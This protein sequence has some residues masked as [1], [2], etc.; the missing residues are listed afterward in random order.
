M[1][2]GIYRSDV[3]V[4]VVLR[5]LSGDAYSHLGFHKRRDDLVGGAVKPHEFHLFVALFNS[6][7]IFAFG[8]VVV[9]N[10]D[11]E[12]PGEIFRVG[13]VNKLYH[14][15]GAYRLVR[16]PDDCLDAVGAL[17]FRVKRVGQKHLHRA[18]GFS[19]RKIGDHYVS[20]VLRVGQ[21]HIEGLEMLGIDLDFDSEII[22]VKVVPVKHCAL[23]R[24]GLV[25]NQNPLRLRRGCDGGAAYRRSE[26]ACAR[27]HSRVRSFASA[28]KYAEQ[29]RAKHQ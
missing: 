19:R 27:G 5:F 6:Q 22:H 10:F 11:L 8:T 4:H 23:L 14:V 9:I 28:E 26:Q 1:E 2:R 7:D 24:R 18:L 3:V 16:R 21:L 25:G 12:L 13:G 29:R 20:A 17:Y 15:V